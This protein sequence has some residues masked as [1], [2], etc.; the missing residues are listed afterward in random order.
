MRKK[1]EAFENWA[2]DNWKECVIG[3]IIGEFLAALT[4]YPF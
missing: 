3:C 4:L 2:Y 1:F